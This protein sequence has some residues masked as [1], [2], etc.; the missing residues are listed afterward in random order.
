MQS[1]QEQNVQSVT[2]SG[3]YF[4]RDVLGMQFKE[5]SGKDS[6]REPFLPGLEVPWITHE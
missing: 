1:I 3:S 4:G 6:T 2:K 5:Q